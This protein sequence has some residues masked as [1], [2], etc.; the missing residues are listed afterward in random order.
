MLH[1]EIGKKTTRAQ[2]SSFAR[3]PEKGTAFGGH[4]ENKGQNKHIIGKQE[5]IGKAREQGA[6]AASSR[7]NKTKDG[8][9]EHVHKQVKP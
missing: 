4:L 8:Y 2:T 5:R 9:I 7:E 1:D 6:E 3:S